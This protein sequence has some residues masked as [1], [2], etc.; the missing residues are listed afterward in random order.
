M[1]P[2][3]AHCPA[4]VTA[5]RFKSERKTIFSSPTTTT[6]V[7]VA[8][9]IQLVS[10]AEPNRDTRNGSRHNW[11]IGKFWVIRSLRERSRALI[12][13]TQQMEITHIFRFCSSK[14]RTHTHTHAKQTNKQ[15]NENT[16]I[17]GEKKFY[18]EIE[19][20]IVRMCRVSATIFLQFA[21]QKK[22]QQRKLLAATRKSEN[23]VSWR[24]E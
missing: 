24:T 2:T 4:P 3:Y 22:R 9:A 20:I 18:N 19:I 6:A 17:N 14:A 7:V 15:K 21:V 11:K 23:N 8:K 5:I 16:A 12:N 1:M 10:R 13:A